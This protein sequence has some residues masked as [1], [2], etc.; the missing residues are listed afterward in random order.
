MRVDLRESAERELPGR[1]CLTEWQ[2]ANIIHKCG[3]N[4]MRKKEKTYI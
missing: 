2:G 3:A 1:K 4:M